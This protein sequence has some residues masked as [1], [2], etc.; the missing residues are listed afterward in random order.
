MTEGPSGWALSQS[1]LVSLQKRIYGNWV[2][3]G[4]SAVRL[5]RDFR[6]PNAF[7]ENSFMP[8]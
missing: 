7:S 5:I 2:L 3:L 6:G 4:G 1:S 8:Q